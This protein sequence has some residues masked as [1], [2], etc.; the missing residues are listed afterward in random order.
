MAG[1]LVRPDGRPHRS[2]RAA[3]EIRHS[4]RAL[5]VAA[6][7]EGEF[8]DAVSGE[9]LAAGVDRR[10]EREKI[11]TWGDVRSGLDRWGTWLAGRLLQGR[12][13]HLP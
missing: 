5:V 3:E 2:A 11:R 8:T 9:L 7:I 4:I 13:G 1:G 6:V 12:T 10:G